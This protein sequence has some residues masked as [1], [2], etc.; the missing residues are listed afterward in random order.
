MKNIYEKKR[1]KNY[2]DS[3]NISRSNIGDDRLTNG[4]RDDGTVTQ[5]SNI[6]KGHVELFLVTTWSFLYDC[7]CY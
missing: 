4:T 7:K 3:S 6:T 2:D 5:Q 1:R